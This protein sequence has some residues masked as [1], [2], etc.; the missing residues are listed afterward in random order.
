MQEAG[1]NKPTLYK[2]WH[3]SRGLQ[4]E[5]LWDS[6]R[7]MNC[8]STVRKTPEITSVFDQIYPL[9]SQNSQHRNL[10]DI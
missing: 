2:A 6:I 10:R 1:F 4:T 9:F 8:Q 7:I 5:Q 3:G